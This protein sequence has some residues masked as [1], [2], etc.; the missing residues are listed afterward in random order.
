MAPRSWYWDITRNGRDC[1]VTYQSRYP[2]GVSRP[3]PGHR[4]PENPQI[5]APG[6]PATR[7]PGSTP[8][9]TGPDLP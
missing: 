8:R 9:S 3:A 5:W 1:T 4:E 7:S 6:A 2:H